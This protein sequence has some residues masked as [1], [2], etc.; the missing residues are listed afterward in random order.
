MARHKNVAV[1]LGAIFHTGREA[2][3]HPEWL[4]SPPSWM[5]AE[6]RD[7]ME[8]LYSI[9]R[10]CGLSLVELTI[11]YLLGDSD[12]S[13]VLVGAASPAEIEE[14]VA[15]AQQGP[16]PQDLHQVLDPLGLP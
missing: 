9:Q 1:V 14:S 7:R 13:T 12:V 11:R 4:T 3:V 10:E 5:T 8:R 16:L 6:L 2:E 15:A